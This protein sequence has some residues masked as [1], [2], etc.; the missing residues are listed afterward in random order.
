MEWGV[1]S[2]GVPKV[3]FGMLDL[4]TTTTTIAAATP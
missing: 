4:A 3:I 2:L 1:T